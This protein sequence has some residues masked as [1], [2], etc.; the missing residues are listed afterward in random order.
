MPFRKMTWVGSEWG[1]G[2]NPGNRKGLPLA[3]QQA[4]RGSASHTPGDSL[5][6][7]TAEWLP[8][9]PGACLLGDMSGRNNCSGRSRWSL[10]RV[11]A[12]G[13]T[14][15]V[16]SQFCPVTGTMSQPLVPCSRPTPPENLRPARCPGSRPSPV[17][18]S[19][20]SWAHTWTGTSQ[21]ATLPTSLG[22]L[23][24]TLLFQC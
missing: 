11:S 10:A 7:P 15:Y 23:S 1:T 18:P 4:R 16:S 9:A 6:K 19:R 14:R 24:R 3:W 17:R 8:G 5:A 22:R 21:A 20:G 2:Q 12:P 13:G